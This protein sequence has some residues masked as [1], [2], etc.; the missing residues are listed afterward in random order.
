MKRTLDM[1]MDVEAVNAAKPSEAHAAVPRDAPQLPERGAEAAPRRTRRERRQRETAEEPGERYRP[2][3]AERRAVAQRRHQHA[4][5]ERA[6]E[7][8]RVACAVDAPV[9]LA[10][11]VRVDAAR[12]GLRRRPVRGPRVAD[13]RLP[14]D[15]HPEVAGRDEEHHA[16]DHRHEARPEHPSLAELVGYRAGEQPQHQSEHGLRRHDDAERREVVAEVQRVERHEHLDEAERDL[17]RE[18]RAVDQQD[19]AGFGAL[20]QLPLGLG[21]HAEKRPGS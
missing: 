1:M 16:R 18:S 7:A 19:G 6:D 4:A 21:A 13:E 17:V 11:A 15:E 9:D 5:Q 8:A 20:V 10:G 14:E 3:D 12:I 2:G